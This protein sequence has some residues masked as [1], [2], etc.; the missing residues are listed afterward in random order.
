[1]VI[2]I[3]FVL[4]N[5]GELFTFG[6]NVHGQLGLGD[7]VNRNVPTLLTTNENLISINGKRIKRIIWKSEIYST[8]SKTKQLEIKTFL[9]VC[10]CYKSQYKI[11]VV[12]Y[13]KHA[14]ISLL[15]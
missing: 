10:H 5:N 14:I 4:H 7:N 13:M 11:N 3:H 1:M 12:K 8:L 9:L 15:F 6:S 2:F